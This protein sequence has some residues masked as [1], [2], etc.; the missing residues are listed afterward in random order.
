[1]ARYV[2]GRLLQALLTLLVISTLAFALTRLVPGDPARLILGPDHSTRANLALL[3]HELGLDGSLFSQYFHFLTGAAH[4]DFGESIH[5]HQPVSHALVPELWPSLW[6]VLYSC[7]I[8][9]L[10]V[11]P[12]ALIAATHR[13]RVADHAIRFASTVGYAAPTFLIGLVLILVF[14]V[15]LG[16]LPVAGYGTGFMGHLRSLTLPALTIALSFAPFL[17]RTLR[18]GLLDTLGREFVEAARSRGLSARRVLM[19]HTMRNSI[20]PTLTILGISVGALLS[21]NVIVENVFS[22]PGLGTLLITSV[23]ARDYPMIQALVVLFAAAV[24]ISNLVTDLL[25][26]VI[27]P[28]IRL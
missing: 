21:A 5:F 24:V 6:L 16:W 2:L 3:H 28:R 27:D 22:I 18:S 13:N 25:Y 26:V 19:K 11:V 12:L 7:A 15:N 20:L 1:M 14:S 10:M 8:S 9:V 23:N 17:L 4:L